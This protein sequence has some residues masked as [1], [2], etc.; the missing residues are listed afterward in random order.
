MLFY[1]LLT[2]TVH[3]SAAADEPMDLTRVSRGALYIRLPASYSSNMSQCHD[4]QTNK[5]YNEGDLWSSAYSDCK[6]NTCVN[7][8]GVLHVERYSCPVITKNVD[9]DMMRRENYFC[10]H[11]WGNRNKA[12]PFCCPSLACRHYVKG[13]M[14]PLPKHMYPYKKIES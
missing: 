3:Q 1:L 6:L 7:I 5:Y 9:F 14:M 10:H 11:A 8:N 4:T 13:R 2:L 12:F